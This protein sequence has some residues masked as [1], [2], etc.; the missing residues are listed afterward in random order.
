LSG[1]GLLQV[2]G[3][4]VVWVNNESRALSSTAPTPIEALC[5]GAP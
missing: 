2:S 4:D 3:A 1:A 5:A